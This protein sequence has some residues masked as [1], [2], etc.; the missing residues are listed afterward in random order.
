M[1]KRTLTASVVAMFALAQPAAAATLELAPEY[2]PYVTVRVSSDAFNP[3]TG[4]F[5]MQGRGVVCAAAV[6]SMEAS[7]SEVYDILG[8]PW[9]YPGTVHVHSPAGSPGSS[10]FTDP[11]VSVDQSSTAWSDTEQFKVCADDRQ[12]NVLNVSAG[13]MNV[14]SVSDYKNEIRLYAPNTQIPIKVSAESCLPLLRTISAPAW[15]ESK[16][17]VTY[18]PVLKW[19]PVTF[20]APTDE[21][22]TCSDPAT[23]QLAEVTGSGA[24]IGY[25]VVKDGSCNFARCTIAFAGKLYDFKSRAVRAKLAC[26]RVSFAPGVKN[27]GDVVRAAT[28]DNASLADVSENYSKALCL[29]TPTK[30][31]SYKLTVDRWSPPEIEKGRGWLFR[32]SSSSFGSHI[33]VNCGWQFE[34]DVKFNQT[35]KTRATVRVSATG[36][37]V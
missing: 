24:G 30:P 29:P 28:T 15:A 31:G 18:L 35:E 2:R 5:E 16:G 27:R 25:V 4:A 21:Y 17:S 13:G 26:S 9:I 11:Y 12:S 1:W 14:H 3:A 34:G 20:A 36:V 22:A 7:R 19:S 33:T 32:C 37:S 10:G 23:A 6:L 8:S